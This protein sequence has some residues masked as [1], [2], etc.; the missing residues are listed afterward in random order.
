MHNVRNDTETNIFLLTD[1]VFIIII[2]AIIF[3]HDTLVV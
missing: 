2:I 3:T 1:K